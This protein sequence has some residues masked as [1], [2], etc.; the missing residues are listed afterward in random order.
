[1]LYTYTMYLTAVKRHF[2]VCDKFMWICQNGLLDKFVQFL[3]MCCSALYIVMYGTIKIYVCSTNL[4]NQCST[5]IFRMYKSHTEICC[6][7]VLWNLFSI[8]AHVHEIT[9]KHPACSELKW[10]QDSRHDYQRAELDATL[11]IFLHNIM[12]TCSDYHNTL[13]YMYMYTCMWT[14][15]A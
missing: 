15:P 14:W 8:H 3:F 5:R 12:R 4:C 13:I 2:Y 1:M 11:K 9:E 7:I 6:F 10:T